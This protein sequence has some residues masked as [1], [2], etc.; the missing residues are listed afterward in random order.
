MALDLLRLAL[1]ARS[2]GGPMTKGQWLLVGAIALS[3]A[4]G[5]YI[6]FFYPTECH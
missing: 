4:V 3:L 5:L 1:H 2:Y 6:V